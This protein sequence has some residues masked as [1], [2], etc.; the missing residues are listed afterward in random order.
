MDLFTMV[1]DFILK[2]VQKIPNL[3]SKM[4]D[5][6]VEDKN[7]LNFF[8]FKQVSCIIVRALNPLLNIE[9]VDLD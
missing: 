2:I 6:K 8:F 4:M 1:Y 7:Q 3:N 9:H 5:E